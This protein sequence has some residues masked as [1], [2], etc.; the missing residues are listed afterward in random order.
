MYEGLIGLLI[1]AVC[2]TIGYLLVEWLDKR[3]AK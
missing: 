2:A 3:E 1:V